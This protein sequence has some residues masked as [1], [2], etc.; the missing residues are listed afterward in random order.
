MRSA[1]PTRPTRPTKL[2]HTL[3]LL[4]SLAASTYLAA[5][6]PSTIVVGGLQEITT[7]KAIPNRELDLLFV[8]DNSPSMLGKQ[9]L[10]AQSFPRMIEILERVDGGLP[11]LHLGVIT[12]DMG[13]LGSGMPTP[14]PAIGQIGSGGC[15][16]SGDDGRLQVGMAALAQPFLSDVAGPDGAR[17]RNYTGELRDVFAQMAQIGQGGCGFEQHLASL[18]RALVQP[19]NAGFLRDDANLAVVIIADEDDCSVLDPT[20]FGPESDDLGPLNSF[21]CTRFGVICQPDDLVPG[22]KVGCTPRAPSWLVEDVQPFVDALLAAKSDPRMVMV[23]AV[24]GDPEPFALELRAPPG[25]GTPVTQLAH[26]CA[27]TSPDGSE[28]ADPAVRLAAFVGGFPGRA[29]LSTLCG[30]DLSTPLQEIGGTA[31][32]LVGDPCLD[33]PALAGDLFDAAEDPGLQPACEVSDVRDSAPSRPQKLPG[34]ESGAADCFEIVA[35]AAACPT[36]PDHLRVRLRRATA[37]AD[38]TWTHVRCQIRN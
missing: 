26:S 5:C 13:T 14:A 36:T 24:A 16:G 20:F 29:Q 34:C 25:G 15:S 21:R 32:K 2:L 37:V 9:R 8:V 38:D 4:A 10:L 22:A 30:G 12:S 31:K 3:A 18:R 6:N 28:V 23:A 11:D 19:A 35:D 7:L 1:R 27:F 17:V 33:V